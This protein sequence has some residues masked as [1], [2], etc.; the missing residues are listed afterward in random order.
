[1]DEHTAFHQMIEGLSLAESGANAMR[2][3]RLD[4]DWKQVAELLGKMKEKIWQ[5]GEAK[6]RQ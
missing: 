2:P 4:Q 6:V 5:L 1:M 3:H